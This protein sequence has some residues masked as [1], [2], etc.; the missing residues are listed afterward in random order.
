M[1]LPSHGLIKWAIHPLDLFEFH[2]NH[3]QEICE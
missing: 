2:V 1:R 3:A